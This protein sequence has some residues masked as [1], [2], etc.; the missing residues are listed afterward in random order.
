MDK[1]PCRLPAAMPSKRPDHWDPTGCCL[2]WTV[3]KETVSRP[4]PW[5]FWVGASRICC[6]GTQSSAIRLENPQYPRRRLTSRL[7]GQT[8]ATCLASTTQNTWRR[9]SML[10]HRSI[11]GDV[12]SPIDGPTISPHPVC[13]VCRTMATLIPGSCNLR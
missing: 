10:T 3:A 11:V 5:S 2:L 12:S 7:R 4:R 13:D 8:P 1:S 6:G 9:F